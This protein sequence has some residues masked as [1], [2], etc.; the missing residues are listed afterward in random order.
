MME[1][2]NSTKNTLSKV[3]FL[4]IMN[5]IEKV[6]KGNYTSSYSMPHLVGNFLTNCSEEK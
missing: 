6:L 4:R 3:L 1:S 2:L 5:F